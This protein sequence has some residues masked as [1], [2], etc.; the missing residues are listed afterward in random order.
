VKYVIVGSILALF[1]P[2]FFGTV[3]PLMHCRTDFTS[4]TVHQALEISARDD[5]RHR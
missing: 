1:S 4:Y 3:K 2:D 5:P